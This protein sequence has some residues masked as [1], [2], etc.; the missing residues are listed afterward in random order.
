MT[1]SPART[2]SP[3]K[4]DKMLRGRTGAEAEL[5]AV[6][7]VFERAGRR[8]PFQFV[9]V[10]AQRCL[11]SPAF[12]RS[13]CRRAISSV[14][15]RRGTAPGSKRASIA[16][17]FADQNGPSCMIGRRPLAIFDDLHRTVVFDLDGTLVDTAPDL[18]NALNFVLDREGLPPGPVHVRAQHDR[19]G[20]PQADRARP[21]T[22]R[23]RCQRRRHHPVDRRLH[24]LLCRRISPTP[25][26]RSKASKA[27]S[28]ISGARISLCGLHQQAGVAVEAAARPARSELALCRDL[29]R[30]H[31]RGFEARPGHPAADG[32]ARGRTHCPP[33]SWSAMPAPISASPAAPAFR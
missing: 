2:R 12:C 1:L 14:V 4:L 11:S 26:A 9:H 10:H 33:R 30:G 29:R 8:L 22:G 20:R 24:R 15:L 16:G 25:R 21:G 13:A 19:R 23:P 7:H 5:H 27:R 18:I 32:R 6:A 3:S 31:V 17:I 28:M